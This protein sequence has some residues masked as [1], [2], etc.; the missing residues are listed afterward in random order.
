MEKPEKTRERLYLI[1]GYALIYRAFFALIS[2]PLVSS[3]GENT[4][5]AFGVARF[6]IKIIDQHQPDYLGMVFD[7]G[8][9]ERVEMYPQYKA[10]REKMPDE[11]ALSIPRIRQLVEAFRIPVLELQGYEAD[12]V[13]GTLAGKAVDAGLEAVIV[14]GDKDFYQLIRPH[15]CLLNPGRG[16]PTAVEEEWVDERNA[17]ERLGVAPKHVVD[18]LGLIGDSSDN[19]PGVSGIGPK[20]AIQ[21]IEQ[22]GSI[23]DIIAHTAEIKSKRAREAL[24]AFADSARLSRRLVT[25]REDLAVDLDTEALRVREPD[26]V[27]LKDLFLDL[28]FNTLARE[29]AAAHPTAPAD[30]GDGAEA[31]PNRLAGDYRLLSTTEEVHA[32]VAQARE[33]GR[34]AVDTE[35][36]SKDPMRATLCGIS[37]GVVVGEA[38]YLPF[39]HRTRGPDQGE[40]LGDATP[41]ADAGVRNLPDLHSPEMQPLLDLLE[42]ETIE[43][44]G[45]NLKYDF[46]VFR[47]EGID[48][49]GIAFDTMVASYILEP[50]R[51]EHGMDS[52]ALQH[53]D[54][55]TITYEEV[56]GKGKA[57]IP[58]AEVE[59]ETAC[60]YAAED[61]D[62]TLRLADKFGPEM[63]ALELD[64]LFRDV[65][66]PLVHVLAE[67]E[68][69]GIRI[70][71]PFFARM[72]E[73]LRATQSQLEREIYAEAGEEFNIGSTPQ[74]REILFGKLGLPV[75][76]KTKTG[77]STDV[78]V[79]QALAAQGHRLPTL[80]MQY[81][82]VDKLRGT[83]VDALPLMVNPETGRIHTS[84]NQTV[85]A[86]GRLSSTDPN[87][88]NIPIRTEMGAEIRRGFIPAEGNV[89]VSADYSQIE[90][91]ILAHYSGDEA[92]VTAFRSG[93]DIHRQTAALIFEVP[94]ESVTKEM[95]DRAKTVN[96]GIIYGQGPFSLA[97]Q[98]GISQAEAKAFI[99]AYFERFPGVRRYL[100][101]QIELARTRGYVETLTG[102]RRYIPEIQSRNWN[103]R[104][105][106]ERAATNAPIQGSSADLIKIAMIRIQNDIA[107]GMVPAKM[108]LQVHDEL[109][110][111]TPIGTEDAVREFVRERME[112][113]ATLNVPLK[114][115]G[116]VGSSWFETK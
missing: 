84:F 104:A 14:S 51:R 42:D 85:A 101:E 21:L 39:R 113:A 111:E 50:G 74:L 38:F 97:Q 53:L 41:D 87:L 60:N 18:Y 54:H 58:F 102:R 61:A 81:R 31:A 116:G 69:N 45:Q 107:A 3:R 105:F 52:L 32:L 80:L 12:D 92:F 17:H 103:V 33:A 27:A 112:G 106:G 9:S 4:S 56:A 115:A 10:T 67:M 28:E 59:L 22:Y 11:L 77:A 114:V 65:E 91:R 26:R 25:I 72:S 90:L 78:D 1:D 46:L 83:Y 6:L 55:R 43:K 23:E 19:V 20:T 99:E 62:I 109:L 94:V 98:L 36:D 47:R 73:E 64:H 70:D 30:A 76:K 37:I 100:D 89:F 82:Q 49:R 24:E 15:V 44:V 108:L 110:F 88:Q 2:R 79:L 34:F 40:L 16:G 7:A 48:L 63:Q 5:A 29:F 95:R 75:I 13:I 86:T 35:T 68:Y 71:E 96:F 93:A 8:D 57:Q 66:L